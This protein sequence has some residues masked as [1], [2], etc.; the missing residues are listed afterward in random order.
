MV[1][2]TKLVATPF[3]HARGMG[4]PLRTDSTGQWYHVVNRGVNRGTIFFDDRDRLE[5]ERLLGL[6]HERHDIVVHA[7]CWMTNHYHL[8]VQCP[9]GQL[10]EA[11]HLLGSLY[12]RH[13]NDRRGRVGPL[14]E[15]RFY[16]K[17]VV[18]EA[19][20]VRL[21]RYIHQNPVAIV[22]VD[23]ER[24]RWTSLRAHLGQRRPPTWLQSVDVLAACGGRD[25]L[26]SLV[27]DRERTTAEPIAGGELLDVVDLMI[28]E[29]PEESA[30]L[31]GNRTLATLVIDRL[32]GSRQLDLVEQLGFGSPRSERSARHRARKQLTAH[33]EYGR[34]LDAVMD[35]AA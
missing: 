5:F 35:L 34:V 25:G 8:L 12:V 17:P 28:D 10:S 24:Y 30:T 23:L 18:T 22:G 1:P 7:Y 21:V 33:P 11:M 2:G 6:V 26:Y 32:E 9:G 3:H 15:R 31:R 13:V 29:F 14:F 20:F 16:A 4:R 27:F 19:Y